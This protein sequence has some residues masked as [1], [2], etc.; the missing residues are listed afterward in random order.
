VT[1]LFV[2]PPKKPPSHNFENSVAFER[3]A[4]VSWTSRDSCILSQHH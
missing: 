1:A 2:E 4:V 3:L